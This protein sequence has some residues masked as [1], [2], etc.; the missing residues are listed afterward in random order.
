MST[1]TP[2]ITAP[3]PP[4]AEPRRPEPAG[5]SAIRS[6]LGEP[7]HGSAPEAVRGWLLVEHPGPWAA[8]GAAHTLPAEVAA[9]PERAAALGLRLQLIRRTRARRRSRHRIYLAHAGERPWLRQGEVDDLRDLD[10]V[11]LE[12]VADGRPTGFGEPAPEGTRLLLVCT[13]GRHDPCCARLGAPVARELA[14][15]HPAEVWET[16]HVGGDR[17]AANIVCLPEGTYHG[18]TDR[19]SAARVAAAALRGEVDLR[20]YRGRAGLPAAAQS[21]EWYA[22]QATGVT[23]A[24]AVA[25][26]GLHRLDTATTLV[27][28]TIAGSP[29]TVIVRRVTD[30]CPRRTS[31]SAATSDRPEYHELVSL[32]AESAA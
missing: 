3:A 7:V 25:H 29:A 30:P 16:T 2:A 17:Y 10:A 20:H 9:V 23:A 8:E 14:G 1:G 11:D 28:L 18:D 21:A 19:G 27:A 12:P 32:D 31:C 4:R 24:A 6:A 15:T 26:V 5:C 13:H 22:R